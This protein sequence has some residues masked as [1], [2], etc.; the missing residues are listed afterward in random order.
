MGVRIIEGD[1]RDVL[2][3]MPEGSVHAVVTSPPYWGL[4]DYGVG[5]QLGLEA[6]P[7]EYVEAMVG[8]GREIRRVLRP[9]GSL[10]LNLGDCYARAPG[11][12]GSGTPTGRNG[13]GEGYAGSRR[14]IPSGLKPKDLVGVPWLVAFA[15]RAD[16]WFL[17]ST[18]IWHK[19]NA[20]PDS[21]TDRP[22][23]DHE[24]IFL[25]TPSETYFYDRFAV[26]QG[27]H[28]MRT[29]WHINVSQYPGAHFAT[30]PLEVAAT[31]IKAATPEG[32][33]CGR[34]GAP[35]GPIVERGKNDRRNDT[36]EQQVVGWEPTCNC[37]PTCVG[38]QTCLFTGGH[39]FAP[40]EIAPPVVLDPFA[41]TGTVGEAATKLG[42]DAILIELNPGSV[43]LAAAR[44]SQRG[45]FGTIGR[46]G[47]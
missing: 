12:G 5:G 6:T 7:E 28:Y 4:R 24:Y 1:C 46:S 40:L 34:C 8:V 30:F 2:P 25:L 22:G 39:Y 32:G 21:A 13:Y 17:R 27:N 41:G 37:W 11:K 31:C 35:F 14:P 36:D 42:R 29:V 47:G 26:R 18:V 23:V 10:W 20:K 38:C 15:L 16:G 43:K 3:S 45:L 9:D 44:N 19:P 33:C